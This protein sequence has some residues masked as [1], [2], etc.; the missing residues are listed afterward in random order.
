[1]PAFKIG[2]RQPHTQRRLRLQFLLKFRWTTAFH[3]L[4]SVAAHQNEREIPYRG[5]TRRLPEKR[6]RLSHSVIAAVYI[7]NFTACHCLA[8]SPSPFS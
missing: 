3:Y 5:V 8:E 2:L 6:M 7:A 4:P 1:V